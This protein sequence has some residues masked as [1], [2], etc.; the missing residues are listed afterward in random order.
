[1]NAKKLA[2]LISGKGTNAKRLIQF[3]SLAE[4]T[5]FLII[6]SKCNDIMRLYCEKNDIF[7]FEIEGATENLNKQI[8]CI[9]EEHLVTHVVLAG[10]L[11]KISSSTVR[12]FQGRMLNLH[13]SLL[14]KFGGSGMYGRRVHQAVF[15]A[16]EVKT[17]ITIHE[18]SEIYDEGKIIAQFEVSISELDSVSK[19]EEKVRQLEKKY[20]P[21]I[22]WK[23]I[24]E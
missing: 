6:S 10:F 9:F 11:K 21:E 24:T 14:P 17:G 4:C 16:G 3:K 15:D 8:E 12:A 13:P 23:F 19:I 5:Q 7:Y 22:V 20:F 2:I 18:V 1:M